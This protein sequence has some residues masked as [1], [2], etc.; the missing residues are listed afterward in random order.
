M[1]VLKIIAVGVLAAALSFARVQKNSIARLRQTNAGLRQQAA[2]AAENQNSRV[3]QVGD[4]QELQSLTEATR[5]LP[6]LRNEVRQLR[7]QRTE[8]DR[9]RNENGKLATQISSRTNRPKLAQME[10][11]VAKEKWTQAGFA[12]PE[13]T[14][15]SFFWA[16]VNQD[17]SYFAQCMAPK[18]KQEF[19]RQFAGKS[20]E[21]QQKVFGDGM[22]ALGRMGGY[23]IAG[24]EYVSEN[25]VVIGIEAAAGGHVIKMPLERIGNEWKLNEPK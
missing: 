18:M 4:D 25:K 6:K 9:L 10:G 5:E 15:Q 2:E 7:Q 22:A 13:A 3:A 11:Y 14:V 1:T 16:V 21:E 20:P 12:T 23:R 19:D 17:T 24:T 8:L